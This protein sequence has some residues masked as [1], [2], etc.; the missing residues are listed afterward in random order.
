[1]AF[2]AH[3]ATALTGRL[4]CWLTGGVMMDTMAACLS[5]GPAALAAASTGTHLVVPCDVASLRQSITTAPDNATLVLTAGCIYRLTSA[6]PD[7]Q[8]NL[9]I[10]GNGAAITRLSGS[11]TMLTVRSANLRLSRVSL[12]GPAMQLTRRAPSRPRLALI[13]RLPTAHSPMTSGRWAGPSTSARA[14]I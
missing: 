1:M 4:R 14:A 13:S 7:V 10:R 3:R 12:T 6:L 11:F 5:A 8:R 2:G 9:T